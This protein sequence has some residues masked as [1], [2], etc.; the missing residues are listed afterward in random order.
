LQILPL[1]KYIFFAFLLLSS[2]LVCCSK[3]ENGSDINKFAQICPI[4]QIIDSM[5]DSPNITIITFKY[6]NNVCVGFD[7]KVGSMDTLI[8]SYDLI[9][10]Q[11]LITTIKEKFKCSDPS[12]KDWDSVIYNINRI[13][14]DEIVIQENVYGDLGVYTTKRQLSDNKIIE[15]SDYSQSIMY[16]DK[17]QNVVKEEFSTVGNAIPYMSRLFVYDQ[18]PSPL[19]NL[20]FVVKMA[21]MNNLLGFPGSSGWTNNIIKFTNIGSDGKTDFEFNLEY[22]DYLYAVTNHS[23]FGAIRYYYGNCYL[24]N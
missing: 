4:L 16:L 12:R 19:Y 18:K 24:N 15:T 17:S 3:K 8:Y 5:P 1:N 6:E 11:N 9:Y 2:L 13:N 21:A 22:S 10:T 20:P 23:Y 7:R 14:K